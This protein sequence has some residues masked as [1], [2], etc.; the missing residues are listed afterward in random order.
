MKTVS[1]HLIFSTIRIDYNS[2]LDILGSS[3]PIYV[4]RLH[5]SSV[6]CFRLGYQKSSPSSSSPSKV[7]TSPHRCVGF[8]VE[9]TIAM[10]KGCC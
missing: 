9:L 8:A 7:S 6:R 3:G 4:H 2:A 1:P 5:P 10:L